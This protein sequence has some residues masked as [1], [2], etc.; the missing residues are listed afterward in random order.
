MRKKI[1][2]GLNDKHII[3]NKKSVLLQLIN[4][5]I[6]STMH[7]LIKKKIKNLIEKFQRTVLIY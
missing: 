7:I 3:L 4:P 5:F 6:Y 2:E 1:S